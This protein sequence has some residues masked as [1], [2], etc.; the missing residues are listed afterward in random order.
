MINIDYD[1]LKNN[2]KIIVSEIFKNY[3]KEHDIKNICGFS[4]YSDEDAMS[5]SVAINTYDYLENSVKDFPEFVLECNKKFNAKHVS[6]EYEQ[7]INEMEED[8]EE[9]YDE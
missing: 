4:L 9:E 7:W 3:I 1:M 8:E 6:E 2:L 5:I